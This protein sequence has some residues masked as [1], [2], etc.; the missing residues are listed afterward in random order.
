MAAHRR[1][2]VPTAL[3][4]TV[5]VSSLVLMGNT[6]GLEQKTKNQTNHAWDILSN[7][8]NKTSP[9]VPPFFSFIC[10]LQKALPDFYWCPFFPLKQ[11]WKLVFKMLFNHRH[12]RMSSNCSCNVKSEE[13]L[14]QKKTCLINALLEPSF[15]CY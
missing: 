7:S 13:I 2:S 8:E 5:K 1:Y 6:C 14:L 3:Q 10:T 15:N 9:P 11:M 4:D 12:W